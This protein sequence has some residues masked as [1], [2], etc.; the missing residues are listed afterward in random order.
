MLNVGDYFTFQA[1]TSGVTP[2]FTP[3]FRLIGTSKTAILRR[4]RPF[5]TVD[6]RRQGGNSVLVHTTFI[7]GRHGDPNGH[8]DKED[9]LLRGAFGDHLRNL[10]YVGSLAV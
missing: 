4:S 6:S 8:G 7:Y 10:L 9:D 5:S 1:L 2:K 3:D